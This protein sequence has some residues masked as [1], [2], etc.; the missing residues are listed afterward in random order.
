[1][2]NRVRH[3]RGHNFCAILLLLLVDPILLMVNPVVMIIESVATFTKKLPLILSSCSFF[4]TLHFYNQHIFT[5]RVSFSQSVMNEAGHIVL[6][7]DRAY[8]KDTVCIVI[9]KEVIC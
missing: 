2:S 1:M 5:L 9:V 8:L 7:S 6:R 4:E 3:R